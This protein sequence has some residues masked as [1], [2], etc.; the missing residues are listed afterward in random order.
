MQ[1]DIGIA[2]INN[3]DPIA[4]ILVTTLASEILG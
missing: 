1:R 3:S 4:M 2:D